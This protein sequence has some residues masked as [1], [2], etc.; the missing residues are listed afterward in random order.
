MD[1]WKDVLNLSLIHIFAD[2]DAG[3][4]NAQVL[5]KQGIGP[6]TD[7]GSILRILPLHSGEKED[8][9]DRKDLTAFGMAGPGFP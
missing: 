7:S 5:T 9:S 4:K 2:T 8:V 1:D 6:R 3:R